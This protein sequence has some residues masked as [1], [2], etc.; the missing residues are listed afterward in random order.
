[1]LQHLLVLC[2]D[3]HPT[4]RAGTQPPTG[5]I[6][7]TKRACPWHKKGGNHISRQPRRELAS[8]LQGAGAERQHR[9]TPTRVAAP[10]SPA[11]CCLH[12]FVYLLSFARQLTEVASGVT[13]TGTNKG[14][15]KGI[16][17]A[18]TNQSRRTRHTGSA[19][20]LVTAAYTCDGQLEVERRI[21]WPQVV[22]PEQVDLLCSHLHQTTS[23]FIKKIPNNSSRTLFVCSCVRSASSHQLRHTTVHSIFH[24]I[25]CCSGHDKSRHAAVRYQRAHSCRTAPGR[26]LKE[27]LCLQVICDLSICSSPGI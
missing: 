14:G 7:A 6:N 4:T 22:D 12:D 10:E 26:D 24:T 18:N 23:P 8:A 19:E 1:M 27:W 11:T 21:R 15:Q 25:S 9:A 16:Q 2:C 20:T 3:R 13:S 5:G 17:E